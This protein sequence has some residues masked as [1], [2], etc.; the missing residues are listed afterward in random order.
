MTL[1]QAFDKV[2]TW[3]VVEKHPAS[4]VMELEMPVCR[5]RGPNGAKCAIGVLIPDE[6]YRPGFE[7]CSA[8]AVAGKP[9]VIKAMKGLSEA[10]L[11]ELQQCHDRA[12]RDVGKDIDTE[13]Q[14][15]LREFAESRSLTIPAPPR[16]TRR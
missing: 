5:Y 3:F 13:I 12:V 6:A 7:Y 9:G 16:G 4:Y 15:R 2:W 1:Q 11:N 10:D 14:E 8:Y